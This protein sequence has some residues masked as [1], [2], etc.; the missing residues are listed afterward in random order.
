[1]DYYIL[2]DLS[3]DQTDVDL[4]SCALPEVDLGNITLLEQNLGRNSEAQILS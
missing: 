2:P 3:I 4:S 1:M